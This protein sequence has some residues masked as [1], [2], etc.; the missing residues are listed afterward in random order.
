MKMKAAVYYGPHD[1]RVEELERPRSEN[2]VD[3]HGMVLKVG[4]C[5]ICPVMDTPRYK[6]VT[7]DHATPI[8][9]GHEFSGEVVEVGPKVTAAKVGDRIYGLTFRPCGRCAP[10]K[11]GDVENCVNYPESTEGNYINGAMSEYMFFPYVIGN[12]LIKL[13]PDLTYRDGSMLEPLCLAAGLA[14]K[15][16]KGDLVVVI[17]QDLMGLGILAFLKQKGLARKVIVSDVSRIR[18]EAA[19]KLGA[20]VVVDETKEDLYKVVEE[21]SGHDKLEVLQGGG[22][23]VVIETSGRSVNF[24]M[25]IDVVRPRGQIWLATFYDE[26]PFLFDPSVQV[27][28]RARSNISQKGTAP[29]QCAWGSLGP[30]IPR[31][32]ESIKLIQSGKFTAAKYVTQVFPLSKINEAFEAAIDPHKSIKVVVEP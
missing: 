22:A 15:A 7:I 29:I 6:R 25:S 5:G 4:A 17:G 32:E 16:K 23:D 21:I 13:P 27:P 18:L 26:G 1:I 8:V 19:R 11:S 12:K 3:G 10:C 28:G 2:G 20:D 9:L 30:W 24:Q 14:D 31:L